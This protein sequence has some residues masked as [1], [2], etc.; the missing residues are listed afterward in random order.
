MAWRSVGPHRKMFCQK[1]KKNMLGTTVAQLRSPINHKYLH[2]KAKRAACK[3][4]MPI[5]PA[6]KD[7]ERERNRDGMAAAD[8]ESAFY[9]YYSKLQPVIQA[10]NQQRA[11]LRDFSTR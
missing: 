4:I 9:R 10:L 8:L 7:E 2:C 3:L 1:K 6:C 11:A 5:F